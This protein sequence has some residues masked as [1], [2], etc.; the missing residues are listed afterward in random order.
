[1]VLIVLKMNSRMATR[2]GG[3]DKIISYST[4]Q[5]CLHSTHLARIPFRGPLLVLPTPA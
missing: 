5:E 2:Q 3:V 4:R 1:M